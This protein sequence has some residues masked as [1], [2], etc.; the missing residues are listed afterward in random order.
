MGEM[1][2]SAVFAL[3][4]QIQDAADV[5]RFKVNSECF[6]CKSVNSQ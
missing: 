3:L 6:L 4:S 2:W 1:C 5:A